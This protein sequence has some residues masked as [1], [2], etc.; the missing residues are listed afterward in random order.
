MREHSTDKTAVD[1]TLKQ[2][3]GKLTMSQTS[4]FRLS[5]THPRR[6]PLSEIETHATVKLSGEE[7][8]ASVELDAEA[9]DHL[10]D[11]LRAIQSGDAFDD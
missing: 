1:A 3:E 2:S 11:E 7:S 10:I 5:V 8:H 9:L 4:Q 6:Q